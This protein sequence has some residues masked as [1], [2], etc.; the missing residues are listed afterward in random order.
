[1][2]EFGNLGYSLYGRFPP[3]GYALIK[4]VTFAF[5]ND[6]SAGIYAARMLML[7]LFVGTVVLAY[8]SL[9]RLTSSKWV[10]VSA[11]ALAFS[12][13]Y[14]L[15][16]NDLISTEFGIDLFGCML[17]FHGMTIFVMEGRF[18]QLVIKSCIALLLGW[19]VLAV[20]VPFVALG[21]FKKVF[22]DSAIIRVHGGI[23]KGFLSK[24]RMGFTAAFTS[25]YIVL[26]IIVASFSILVLVG[27]IGHQYYYHN[28]GN[29]LN[30]KLG[31]LPI[32][33]AATRRLGTSADS[34]Y[35]Q[36]Q[37]ES[38]EWPSFLRG[39]FVRIGIMS[40]P[41][42]LPGYS[43]V[44]SWWEGNSPIGVSELQNL[45]T[46]IVV[47]GICVVGGFFARY[48]LLIMTAVLAGFTWAIPWRYNVV[49]HRWEAL[50][51]VG[52]PLVAFALIFTL[53]R[54]LSSEL[55]VGSISVITV[56][57]FG[58]SSFQ[59]SSA[60]DD[61]RFSAEFHQT[62]MDDFDIIRQFTKDSSVLVPVTLGRSEEVIEF[63][64]SGYGLFYYL[65]GSSI[66][67]N[68]PWCSADK[69]DFIPDEVDFIIQT[70]RDMPGLLTPNNQM[71]YLYDQYV[72]EKEIDG[73]IND[74]EALYSF[75]GLEVYLTGDRRLLYIADRCVIDRLLLKSQFFLD[76][77]PVVVSDL[78]A[79]RRSYGYDR[80]DFYFDEHYVLDTKRHILAFKL[81]DYD[82]LSIRAGQLTSDG[83]LIWESIL[84]PSL[85]AITG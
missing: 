19:H 34:Q 47:V 2:D 41:F 32:F 3:G 45:L 66:V 82:I 58:F 60:S 57:I 68:G 1:M 28:I 77:I 70:R 7:I 40:I 43:S 35:T 84:S 56:L 52:L 33:E 64:G 54:K 48:R 21:L 67:F 49:F 23:S 38:T 50:Y 24:I 80:F 37:I 78:P 27:N 9:C 62:M 63:S 14:F 81:P 26:G 13:A 8:W 10:A 29:D 61:S 76:I 83:D 5:E 74:N 25:R 11:T 59:M 46:G 30:T 17:V 31:D 16:F 85:G 72:Y 75:A 79:Q 12:S 39:Q 55:F 65:S 69:V 18:R 44:P 42:A 6:L 73:F 51:Y 71:V 15:Y 36:T 4:L 20:L 53:V 22:V